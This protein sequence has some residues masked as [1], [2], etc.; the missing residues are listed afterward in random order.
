MKQTHG[1]VVCQCVHVIGDADCITVQN[2]IDS[3]VQNETIVV[4]DNIVILIILCYRANMNNERI[5]LKPE[6]RKGTTQNRVW[7]IQVLETR[8]VL[9]HKESC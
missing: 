5:F 7:D 8:M 9:R 1:K 2:A 4:A 6:F 3:S